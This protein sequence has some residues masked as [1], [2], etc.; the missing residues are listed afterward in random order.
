MLKNIFKSVWM[1]APEERATKKPS[2]SATKSEIIL[3]EIPL[4]II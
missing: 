1:N 3:W 2:F 4:L